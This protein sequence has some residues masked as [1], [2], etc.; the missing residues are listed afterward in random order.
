MLDLGLLDHLLQPGNFL[1]EFRLQVGI[2]VDQLQ[3]SF[4]FLD[5]R[6]QLLI[7]FDEAVENLFFFR[8]PGRLLR[9]A[10]DGRIGQLGVDVLD[11]FGLLGYFKET[12][13]GRWI[14]ASIRRIKL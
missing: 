1:L 14:S 3:I 8:Q 5:G 9:F 10:P 6:I 2:F 12:P 11:L 7:D 13:E 4:Q